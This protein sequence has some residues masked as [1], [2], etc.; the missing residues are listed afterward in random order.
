MGCKQ[1]KSEEIRRNFSSS[2]AETSR[3]H[4]DH[5]HPMQWCSV[6]SPCSF[7]VSYH[8][9]QFASLA[10]KQ[11][12]LSYTPAMVIRTGTKGTKGRSLCTGHARSSSLLQPELGVTSPVMIFHFQCHM[13]IR[14]SANSCHL[15]NTS[16]YVYPCSFCFISQGKY[17]VTLLIQ[18]SIMN[19]LFKTLQ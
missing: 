2:G 5:R 16:R 15:I 8:K 3:F 1:D 18:G 19:S 14:S 10:H 13:C 9:M 4:L 7:E 12:Y 6:N 11:F 17:E